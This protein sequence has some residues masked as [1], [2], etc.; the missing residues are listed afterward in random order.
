MSVSITA[1]GILVS[2]GSI[3][4]LIW[5][6]TVSILF[7]KDVCHQT[8]SNVKTQIASIISFTSLLISVIM[9]TIGFVL[10]MLQ[11]KIFGT[12]HE[13]SGV[14][15]VIGTSG[16]ALVFILRIH[17]T[18]T[19]SLSTFAYSSNTIKMLYISWAST[20]IYFPF[21]YIAFVNEL[22]YSAVVFVAL[23]LI[24][25]SMVYGLCCVLFV[26]KA[27]MIID[28]F[29]ETPNQTEIE[30]EGDNTTTEITDNEID[31]DSVDLLIKFALLSFISFITT[32][33]S[34]IANMAAAQRGVGVN[35]ADLVNQIDI[36]LKMLCIYLLFTF[37][38]T[39][40][41]NLCGDCHGY[42][43]NYM[44]KQKE[45]GAILHANAS[46]SNSAICSS[47]WT[48]KLLVDFTDIYYLNNQSH[49][50]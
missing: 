20:V 15:H 44:V 35:F 45:N 23:P 21:I 37:S 46:S 43:R 32:L 39:V 28:E 10:Y 11:N 29:T 4:L 3:V 38:K 36:F 49:H 48:D 47:E 34:L 17:Y 24:H 22:P 16:L 26:K 9:S 33:L 19:G 40:Y 12:I 27:S 13:I 7:Y 30:T 1:E 2:D 14:F 6:S 42:L 41:Y 50:T 25:Y 8:E 31:I 18:F 5:W